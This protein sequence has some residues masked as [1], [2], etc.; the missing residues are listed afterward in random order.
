M[1]TSKCFKFFHV[2]DEDEDEDSAQEEEKTVL[3][4]HSAIIYSTFL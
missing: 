4:V 1:R 3:I 2:N